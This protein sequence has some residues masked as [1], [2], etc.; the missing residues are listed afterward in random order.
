[1]TSPPLPSLSEISLD[2]NADGSGTIA[3]GPEIRQANQALGFTW[4]SPAASHRFDRIDDAQA[5][6]ARILE[7]QRALEVRRA[8]EVQRLLAAAAFA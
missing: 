3:F 6:Y 8:I 1:V 5:V 7:A 2:V 4:I